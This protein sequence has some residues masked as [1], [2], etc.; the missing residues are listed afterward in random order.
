MLKKESPA[1][2]NW[3]LNHLRVCCDV[4]FFLFK[5]K[6]L[7][8]IY[9]KKNCLKEILNH[10]TWGSSVKVNG[11][12]NAIHWNL[13]EKI[14]LMFFIRRRTATNMWSL[15]F[16]KVSGGLYCYSNENNGTETCCWLKFL[17]DNLCQFGTIKNSIL[18][19]YRCRW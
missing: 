6:C 2:Y 4:I 12:S 14:A 9:I 16:S 11:T 13:W 19:L 15:A 3:I 7:P 1:S 8:F 18:A 5:K 17:C 10:K